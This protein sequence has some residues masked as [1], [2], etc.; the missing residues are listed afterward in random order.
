[1][2]AV[3]V[4]TVLATAAPLAQQRLS[5]HARQPR[6]AAVH[7]RWV[8]LPL[9]L[10]PHPAPLSRRLRLFACSYQYRW[11]VQVWA[12]GAL[13]AASMREEPAG[14]LCARDRAAVL[15]VP[16]FPQLLLL[17]SLLYH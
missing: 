1:V 12:V 6:G 9:L 3:G 13:E 16:S 8:G 10:Q 5:K 2:K 7:E 17:S 4:R 11:V 15:G 14:E